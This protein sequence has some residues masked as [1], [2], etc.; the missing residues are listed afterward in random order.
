MGNQL[1]VPIIFYSAICF[2]YIIMYY[3][4]SSVYISKEL[5]NL[6]VYFLCVLYSSNATPQNG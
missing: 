1:Y 4:I 6:G 5:I 2:L 3:H